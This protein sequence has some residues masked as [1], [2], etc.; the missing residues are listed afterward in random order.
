MKKLFTFTLI[1]IM[2]SVFAL[3]ASAD[4]PAKKTQIDWL[5][6]GAGGDVAASGGDIANATGE[7]SYN[8]TSEDGSISGSV[9]ANNGIITIVGGIEAVAFAEQ[10]TVHF[11][12]LTRTGHFHASHRLSAKSTE[13]FPV[14][15]GSAQ[16]MTFC[17]DAD[18]NGGMMNAMVFDHVVK[19][20]F[21]LSNGGFAHS[22]GEDED[23]ELDVQFQEDS[24]AE[25]GT[26]TGTGTN[27]RT[28]AVSFAVPA[29]V[30]TALV[31]ISRKR[32]IK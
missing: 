3:T 25:T 30:V 1:I 7:F 2:L 13:E 16:L 22:G 23:C 28:G 12:T 15:L 4:V 32:K 18:I 21:G 6:S 26:E 24:N 14:A 29:A 17:Y 8:F 9:S 27:P 10:F 19:L 31:I 20:V 5:I 11:A